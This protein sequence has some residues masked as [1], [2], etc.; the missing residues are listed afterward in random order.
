MLCCV[1]NLLKAEGMQ[2]NGAAAILDVV[3]LQT[4]PCAWEWLVQAESLGHMCVTIQYTNIMHLSLLDTG[5]SCTYS[6]VS[7][8]EFLHTCKK[9]LDIGFQRCFLLNGGQQQRSQQ[10]QPAKPGS[11]VAHV[12][13]TLFA[14]SGLTTWHLTFA[15]AT[16]W[17]ALCHQQQI[18][19][20]RYKVLR[21]ESGW[22]QASC[23]P[24]WHYWACHI[25]RKT[26]PIW[27]VQMEGEGHKASC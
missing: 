24:F 27:S 9:I 20:Q 5:T 21:A 13:A 23:R 16:Q 19:R 2:A 3:A 11:F 22:L 18:F 6:N 1:S 14:P 17:Q 15:K 8:F 26:H 10:P 4:L 12:N 25:W 7:S